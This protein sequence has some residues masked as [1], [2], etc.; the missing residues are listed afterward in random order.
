MRLTS[1]TGIERSQAM[2]TMELC[3]D[4]ESTG[5][6]PTLGSG[7]RL[8]TGGES[9][10]AARAGRTTAQTSTPL[11]SSARSDGVENAPTMPIN[12]TRGA[13]PCEVVFDIEF[14]IIYYCIK[15]PRSSIS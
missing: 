6:E 7:S 3:S 15:E 10:D 9:F 11:S 1:H 2:F 13:L 14:S 4:D 5:S 8:R 12:K